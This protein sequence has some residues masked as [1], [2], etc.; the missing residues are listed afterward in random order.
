MVAVQRVSKVYRLYRRPA[1]RI[2]EILPFSSAKHCSDFWALRDVNL[3][4]ER[5]EFLGIVGP[6]GSGKST[7]LQILSGIVQPTSGRVVTDGR[8]AALLELGAGFNPEF[9]GRE[10]VCINGEILGLSRREMARVFPSIEAFADIGEFIDQPVKEY[11]SGMYVRLA[12]ATAIH[13]EPE[14]LIVD[15]ALA[16]GDAAFANRCIHKFEDL[17][18]KQ[19]TVLFVS[20]DLG[21]VK[22]LSDRAVL[23][24]QGRIAA[25]GRPSD[26]INRYV[27][28]VL[29][30]ERQTPRPENDGLNSSYRHGDGSSQVLEVQMLDR[31]GNPATSIRTGEQVEVKVR[32]R[33]LKPVREPVV[34]LLIRNRLGID[35]FGTNTRLQQKGLGNFEAGEELEVSFRFDCLLTQQ[36]YTL[37]VATQHWD[38][39]SQDW[40][41]DVVSFR[42]VDSVETAGLVNLHTEIEWRKTREQL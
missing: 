22:R 6:N 20:H 38:G 42:V 39:S 21:L 19:V 16:V 24:L 3:S 9:T 2:L 29:E 30:R 26:V 37:T 25:E 41:D 27:G 5:G 13:V 10:N 23:L 35:V 28:H 14:I 17:K 15:E 31:Q 33:F 18:R 8:V 36:E 32:A 12:F 4:V 11:S 1:D 34:G 40:L 7:L